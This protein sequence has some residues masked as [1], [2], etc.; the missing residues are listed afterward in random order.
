MKFIPLLTCL[1]FIGLKAQVLHHQSVSSQGSKKLTQSGFVVSQ[2]IGQIS[3]SGTF[4]NSDIVVQ[5][6][7]QQYAVTKYT[8]SSADIVTRVYPNPFVNSVSFE[9]SQAID[10]EVQISLFDLSGKLIVTLLKKPTNKV[11]EIGLEDV[12]EGQYLVLLSAE[13]FKYGTKI[14]KTNKL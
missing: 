8:I 14:I 2:S 1:S 3:P 11:L 13:G 12:F 5:Q 7:F 10:S 6:G 9:F 4:K